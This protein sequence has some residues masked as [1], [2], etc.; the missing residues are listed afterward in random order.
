MPYGLA[1]LIGFVLS[2]READP[3]HQDQLMVGV[4]KTAARLAMKKVTKLRWPVE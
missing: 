4:R 2:L 3:D 1:P